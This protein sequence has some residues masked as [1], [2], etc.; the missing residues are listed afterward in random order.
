VA[1]LSPPLNNSYWVVPGRVLAGEYP[2][3][4]GEDATLTRLQ[5]L[6]DAGIDCF[7]DLTEPDEL[8]AY[9]HLLPGPYASDA[10][11]YLRKPIRDH[12]LPES[13]A[14]MEDI[15][16]ELDSALDEGRRIYLHCRAGIGRTN[17]VAGCWLARGGLAGEEALA[18]LNEL[19]RESARARSWPD[20]PETE[21]Q[22]DFVRDW[23]SRRTRSVIANREAPAAGDLRDRYRGLL[24]GL[25]AGDALG[26]ATRGQR[27]GTFAIGDELPG[28]GPLG[29]PA[30]AWADKAA[31]AM[32]LAESL[33]ACSGPDAA[34]QIRRYRQWQQEGRWSSTG[35]CVGISAATT[36]AL[37]TAQ[38]TGNPYAGSHDPAR[39]DAEPLA[40]I[41]PAVAGS[42]ANPPAAI[43][44]AVSCARITHQ[45]PVTLDAVRYFAG[46]LAGALSGRSK[47]ELLAP[48]FSPVPGIWDSAPLKPRVRD[49]AA[50]SWRR[51][52]PRVLVIGAHAAAGA[53]ETALW[54]FE[55][56]GN[57]QECLVIAASL[58]GEADSTAAIVGQL[59]GAHYGAAALP[60]GW[61]PVI[62][63]GE[64]IEALADALLEIGRQ[65]A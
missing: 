38:W 10:V 6:L 46:L 54:A 39:A 41:G 50:G 47:A 56:G 43:E 18:R 2:C 62:A 20:V 60:P 49:V 64:E 27:P 57:L 35:R 15:L 32:C 40:R 1:L 51:S 19:W 42:L 63:R 45:A 16:D 24:L 52:K 34:D 65:R 31:M 36:R 28:G 25:A 61:R 29:L 58:G 59:A 37:A 8:D 30:G 55:R 17:L 44:A 7:I 26:Q 4:P 21:A 13:A 9:E 53:L 11:I 14:Q 12:G 3:G 48:L 23:R 5:C 22:R 33:V